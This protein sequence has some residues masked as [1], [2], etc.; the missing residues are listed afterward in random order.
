[1]GPAAM[2][3]LLDFQ[4][5]AQAEGGQGAQWSC[6]GL[7]DPGTTLRLLGCAISRSFVLKTVQACFSRY[8][9]V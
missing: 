8:I 2:A 4:K 5:W 7:C 9:H 1:M 6:L 3:E